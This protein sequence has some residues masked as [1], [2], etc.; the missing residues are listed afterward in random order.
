MP[1]KERQRVWR[2]E[3]K[4]TSGG[5]GKHDLV[6]NTRGKIVSKRKSAS[7]SKENNLGKWLRKSG[8]SF[9]GKLIDA[10][11]PL[12]K[13]APKGKPPK[14]PKPKVD[15][16]IAA[17]KAKP[18]PKP[19]PQKQ[20]PKPKA[21]A[22]PKQ[23]PKPIKRKKSPVKAGQLK[24]LSKISV[25]NIVVKKKKVAAPAGWPKWTEKVLN[26]FPKAAAEMKDLV[27]EY[28]DDGEKVDWAV[29]KQ[30]LKDEFFIPI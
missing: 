14:A 6:R 23:A 15:R 5:L 10:G 24:N 29:I 12:L 8:D 28:E 21:K 25:G 2:G 4:K 11:K 19:K 7:S 27:E 17:L 9:G 22:K 3:L 26:S 18:K 16:K 13:K 30:E 1:Q 20:A